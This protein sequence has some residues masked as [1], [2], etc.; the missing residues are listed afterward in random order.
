MLLITRPI[1]FNSPNNGE[2]W[3]DKDG[4]ICQASQNDAKLSPEIQKSGASGTCQCS[5]NDQ[6][7]EICCKCSVGGC[8]GCSPSGS[9]CQCEGGDSII[10][11]DTTWSN[12]KNLF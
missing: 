8:P 1:I 3:I 5:T 6:G 2:T 9:S 10:P 4:N 11:L 7:E 12:I